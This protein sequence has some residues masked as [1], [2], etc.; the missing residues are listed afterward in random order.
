MHGALSHFML[1]PSPE[2][3]KRP[4]QAQTLFRQSEDRT[5]KA[6]FPSS[7]RR[8]LHVALATI[9][10]GIALTT[11]AMAEQR[12]GES[13]TKI[14]S[15]ADLNLNAAAG[16]RTLYGRLR[17]AATQ[18]CAPFRGDTL[19]DKTRWRACFDPALARSVAEID[20]PMLTA[21]HLSR[22]GETEPSTRVAKD[23]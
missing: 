20:A 6:K 13:L 21:I 15:Y 10:C 16:A 1:I 12:D 19:K 2:R 7:T 4:A 14:V 11:P 22:T 5:L 8:S 9:A 23:Q 17:M 18:V 3:M